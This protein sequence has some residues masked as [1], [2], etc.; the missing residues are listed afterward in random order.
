MRIDARTGAASADVRNVVD[1]SAANA[2]AANAQVQPNVQEVQVEARQDQGPALSTERQG[3]HFADAGQGSIRSPFEQTVARHLAQATRQE[4]RPRQQAQPR[5]FQAQPQ[6]MTFAETAGLA[7]PASQPRQESRKEPAASGGGVPVLDASRIGTLQTESARNDARFS[8]STVSTVRSAVES[9]EVLRAGDAPRPGASRAVR[10]TVEQNNREVGDMERRVTEAAVSDSPAT[11]AATGPDRPSSVFNRSFGWGEGKRQPRFAQASMR[12]SKTIL[13]KVKSRMKSAFSR[14][15]VGYRVYGKMLGKVDL[16]F[17]EVGVGIQEIVAVVDQDPGMLS[18]LLGEDV[19]SWSASQLAEYVNSRDVYVGT[20]KPP[21]NRGQDVQRR[22]LRILTNERRGIYLHPVMAAMYT[23]D[24]DGDDMEVSFDPAVAEL[25]KDPMDYMVGIDGQQSL[26]TDFLPVVKVVDLD[27]KMTADKVVSDVILADFRDMGLDLRTLVDAVLELG[28]TLGDGDA[29]ALAW[30]KVFETARRI[31]DANGM[32]SKEASDRLTSQLIQAVYRGMYDMKRQV[33]YSTAEVDIVEMQDLPTPRTYSD[34]AIYRVLDGIIDG[35]APNNFQDLKV[36]MTGFLGNVGGKNAPFRFTADVGKMLKMDSRLKVG[37]GSFRVDPDNEEQMALFFESTMKYAESYVMA[38]EIKQAGRSQYYT[39]L[40]RDLVIKEVGFPDSGRYAYEGGYRDFL[41]EFFESYFRHSTIINESNLVYLTDMGLSSESNRGV[42]SPISS[43]DEVTLGDLAEPLSAIYGTYSVGKMFDRLSTSGYMGRQADTV[44]SGNPNK[45]GRSVKPVESEYGHA[46]DEARFWVTGKYLGYSLRQFKTENRLIGKES[47]LD[48]ERNAKGDVT[49]VG[50]RNTKLSSLED[51]DVSDVDLQFRMLLAIAD[52]GTGVASKFNEKNYGMARRDGSM[53]Y[54]GTTVQMMSDLLV[55]LD[56]QDRLGRQDQMLWI[57]DI[58]RTLAESGPD[59]FLH[60]GMDTTAGLLQSEY[61]RQMVRHNADPEVLGGIRTAMVFDYRMERITA[62]EAELAEAIRD[63]GALGEHQLDL[64]SSLQLAK[65][66]LAASSEVWRGIIREFDAEA[67]GKEESVFQQMR[68]GVLMKSVTKGDG[69]TRRYAWYNSRDR[70]EMS[71]TLD[72]RDFWE[73]PGDHATL[74]SVIED[75]DIDRMTKWNVITDVVRYWENDAYLKS[76][77]VGYQLEIGNDASYDLVGGATQAALGTHKD[78]EKAFNKWADLSQAKLQQEVDDAY[79]AYGSDPKKHGRLMATLRRLDECPWE[80]VAI[81]GLMYADSIMSVKDKSYAQTEKG[82]QHPWTNAVYS[83]LCSQRLGGFMSDVT[84]TDDRMVGIQ[85]TK[86]LGIQDVIHILNDPEASMS[87]YNEYG[88]KV[89]LTRDL[90]LEDALGHPVG[91]DVEADIWEFLRRNPRIASAV[92]MHNACVIADTDGGGYIGASLSLSE[93]IHNATTG[94]RDPLGH[95]RYLMRDHPVYAG[96]ISLV[97]PAIPGQSSVTRNER[98]RVARIERYLS[99]RLYEAARSPEP[100]VNLA[101]DIMEDLGI[102]Q[103]RLREAMRSRYDTYLS[104]RGLPLVN[105]DGE[106]D[107]DAD[108]IHDEVSRALIRYIDE[109]RSSVSMESAAEVPSK[110]RLLGV[111][112][113][114][115]ASF[116]DVVQELG[117]AKTSVSTG[118][119]GAET[120]QFAEW[121]SHVTTKDRYAD[122][123]AIPDGDVTPE[124]NGMWTSLTYESGA[125]VYLEVDSDGRISNTF[126]VDDGD[127]TREVDIF[128]YARRQ[129]VGEVVTMVPDAYTVK[130]RSTDSF[131]TQVASLFA[132]MVSKRS[133]GAEAFNLKA[134]KAGIDKEGTYGYDSVTKMPSKYRMVPDD[135]GVLG[136]ANI[137]QTQEQLR[138]VAQDH[139]EDGFNA[140][141]MVLAQMMLSENERLGYKDLSIPNYM[142]I[143]D[144]MLIQGDD[145]NLYLRSLEMLFNAIKY[146]LGPQVDTMTESE[147][148]KAADAIVH[149]ASET[150][151]GIATMASTMDALMNIVP[152]RKSSSTSGIR[153]KSSVFERNYDLLSQ[154]TSD[155]LTRYAV[156]PISQREASRLHDAYSRIDGIGDVLRGSSVTRNYSVVGYAAAEDG[157]EEIEWTVGASNAIVIGTSRIGGDRVYEIFE[158]AYD[159]GMT[160]IVSQENRNMIPARFRRDMMP[161]GNGSVIVPC[162]DMRLNGSEASPTIGTRFATFQAP[163]SRYV[164][165]VEDSVN[166]FE[167]GDAQAKPTSAFT[168]RIKVV[169]NGSQQVKAEDLFPNV[170]RNPAYSHSTLTVSLA[171]GTEVSALIAKGVRCTIDYG[172]VKGARGFDQRVH[173]VNEA[174]RRYQERWSEADDDGII[175]GGMTECAPGDIV[176]WAECLITD[177]YTGQESVVLAPIIPFPLHG[178]TKN[179]PERF[180]VEQLATVDKDNT[181]FAVDWSNTSDLDGGFA[182]YFD[183]S[184]GANKGMISFSD[185]LGESRLLRDGTAVDVYIAKASTDS[186]KIGT[187]RRIKTMISLMAL[188]R[189]HGYNFASS[190]GAFP[191]DTRL[192]DGTGLRDAM[193][194]GRV[195]AGEWRRLL[196]AGDITFTTDRQLNAFLNY[197]CRKVIDNGG[198]PYDYLANTYTDANGDTQNTH[199]MWEFEAMFDQGINYEDGLLRFLHTMDPTFCPN[200]IDDMNDSYDFRLWRDGSGSAA[201]YDNGVLQMQVPHSMSDGRTAYVWDNVYVGMSFFGEDYSGFSRPN[202]NGASNFLDAMNTMSYYGKRLDSTSARFRAMWAS[203]DIG[204]LPRDGGAIGRA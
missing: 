201:G 191:D 29:Q 133:N 204:R 139:G 90:L 104:M 96:I 22:R 7:Q 66:E 88:E 177:E 14:E 3:R 196:D 105:D 47:G 39:Q 93:T 11:T 203:A 51:A 42:V 162:F 106:S 9:E 23:A 117:G 2:A 127:G 157:T 13:D 92:R 170:F 52:K 180:T 116:W 120:Y 110:P 144:L 130:D 97:S 102:T 36:A 18:Q 190:E 19:S 149:D 189:M 50:I 17:R 163:Y 12:R 122:L 113:M 175:R 178:V 69:K 129:N 4:E 15:G 115:C 165:S 198:N 186:R 176:G 194:S 126:L 86:S 145:G 30:A 108:G 70:N 118:I 121:A 111:D 87:L 109:I 20:F 185:T 84:R 80:T 81:D 136:P 48:D 33:I 140:A 6:G 24:F 114:S 40:M 161:C 79:E 159:L 91:A 8:P 82:S 150:G 154:I 89:L 45:T 49:K 119:E 123:D 85:S 32:G 73:N 107:A 34:Q 76:Y 141:K 128:E 37:D 182:K 46:G 94:A 138:Q 99:A 44:W 166:E 124:W 43:Y 74:R 31:G 143:A 158:K 153:M 195:P 112:A 63:A 152:K 202:I 135:E 193:L 167:L 72:A 59:M 184:G 199:V 169:D 41:G 164:V 151:V 192:S 95:V 62:L 168:D 26:N 64:M 156:E 172:L 181:L 132:Y 75:L 137:E 5:H 131:G 68:G 146:R 100:G 147:I 58:A 134:K 35:E 173:D 98:Q 77:E 103:E 174:I 21:N 187:D 38:K 160:V 188:A 65:D 60:F 67:S 197:E 10:D 61:T 125:P 155:A 54:E 179:V 1:V 101:F 171:S 71:V 78:F 56:R 183:S 57:N 148:R 27:G 142:S 16:D 25:A 53:S 200:G 83:A 55:E 28:D